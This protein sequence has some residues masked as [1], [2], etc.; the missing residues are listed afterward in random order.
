MEGLVGLGRKSEAG[1][2]NSLDTAADASECITT[3]PDSLTV[4]RPNSFLL[5]LGYR[6]LSFR[7]HLQPYLDWLQ[8]HHLSYSERPSIVNEREGLVFEG[9]EIWAGVKYSKRTML[10]FS[11]SSKVVEG[12]RT[13]VETG[14]VS[15]SATANGVSQT[16]QHLVAYATLVC[17]P[18]CWS[19]PSIHSIYNCA[20]LLAVSKLR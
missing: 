13:S 14:I 12:D 15:Q 19:S 10:R 9:K 5:H 7:Y 16:L 20:R 11:S 2:W 8:R 3:R 4:H 1:S 17:L 6:M 18:L